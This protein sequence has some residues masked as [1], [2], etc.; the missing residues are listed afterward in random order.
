MD[1]QLIHLH[2]NTIGVHCVAFISDKMKKEKNIKMKHLF[3]EK[4]FLVIT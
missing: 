2:T 4:L 1:A 3:A